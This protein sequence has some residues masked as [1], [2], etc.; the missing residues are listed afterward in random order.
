MKL[1]LLVYV[2]YIDHF[3]EH[4]QPMTVAGGEEIGWLLTNASYRHVM[5]SKGPPLQAF[6][7]NFS[8]P[9]L[10]PIR[11]VKARA[12]ATWEISNNMALS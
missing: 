1:F 4:T 7:S 10:L 12:I 3:L 8:S 9:L 6:V 11:A 2:G 5:L